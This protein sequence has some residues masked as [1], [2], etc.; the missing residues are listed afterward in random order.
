[1][2]P[3]PDEI[4]PASTRLCHRGATTCAPALTAS[5]DI[6]VSSVPALS[7][8]RGGAAVL[9][10]PRRGHRHLPWRPSNRHRRR[11][12]PSSCLR[13]MWQSPRKPSATSSRNQT[14]QSSSKRCASNGEPTALASDRV[15][16]SSSAGSDGRRGRLSASHFGVTQPSQAGEVGHS[17]ARRPLGDSIEAPAADG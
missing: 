4:A 12:R 3:C 5:S 7:R 11:K 8:R 14:K 6:G 17:L 1:M 10:R 13:L 9:E 16:H 2:V 15:E